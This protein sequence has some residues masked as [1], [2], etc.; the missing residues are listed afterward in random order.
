VEPR[1]SLS[2]TFVLVI[3]EFV[4]RRGGGGGGGGYKA[5]FCT[6]Q[7]FYEVMVMLFGLYKRFGYI[8]ELGEQY[9]CSIA[10]PECIDLHGMHS[11]E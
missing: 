7:G 6:H 10:P 1:L 11:C 5:A 9:F 4:W 3:I 2:W 8:L